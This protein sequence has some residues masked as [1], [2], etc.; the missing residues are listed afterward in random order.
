MVTQEAA[1][2]FFFL[3]TCSC[4]SDRDKQNDRLS[5]GDS[6]AA[7]LY[8]IFLL[9]CSFHVSMGVSKGVS[10]GV[11]V[12]AAAAVVVAVVNRA[13]RNWLVAR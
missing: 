1:P 11:V 8:L 4:L 13:D 10:M 9:S 12:V 2:S 6:T 7:L 3:L 5:A